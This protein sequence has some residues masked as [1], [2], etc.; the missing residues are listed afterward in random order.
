MKPPK[1]YFLRLRSALVSTSRQD[2]NLQ[3]VH[4]STGVTSC[5]W[6]LEVLQTLAY[7]WIGMTEVGAESPPANPHMLDHVIACA[8]LFVTSIII[9]IMF[10]RLHVQGRRQRF[11]IIHKQA[12]C[13]C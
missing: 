9:I 13:S 11:Y 6:A 1:L 2:Q 5:V 10:E 12:A 7:S 4:L 3:T 8:K